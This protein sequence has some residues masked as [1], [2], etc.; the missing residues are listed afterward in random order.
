M[1]SVKGPKQY[2]GAVGHEENLEGEQFI[3]HFFVVVV[4]YSFTCFSHSKSENF[5]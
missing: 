4:V 5:L 2:Q 1:S 3:I